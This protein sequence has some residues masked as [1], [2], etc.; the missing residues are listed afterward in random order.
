MLVNK[1][2]LLEQGVYHYLCN[3]LICSVFHDEKLL[4]L[5]KVSAK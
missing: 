2:I 3:E 1:I 4:L 5:I